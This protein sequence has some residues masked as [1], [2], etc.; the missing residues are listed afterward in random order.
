MKDFIRVYKKSQK[1]KKRSKMNVETA[2][3]NKEKKD[4][5]VDEN[6]FRNTFEYTLYMID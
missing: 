4:F 1:Y 2:S 6:I 5:I 3:D